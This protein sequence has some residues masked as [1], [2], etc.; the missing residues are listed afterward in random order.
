MDYVVAALRHCGTNCCIIAL[1][2]IRQVNPKAVE[3]ITS[4]VMYRE[5]NRHL[6][7]LAQ[8]ISQSALEASLA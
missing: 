6:I 8:S 4:Q 5:H 2:T 3:A 7:T 1:A